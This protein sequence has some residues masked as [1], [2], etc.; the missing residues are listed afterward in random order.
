MT[1]KPNPQLSTVN[2]QLSIAPDASTHI[3]DIAPSMID[4]A[5]RTNQP[6]E[7]W[8]VPHAYHLRYAI[9]GRHH[10]LTSTAWCRQPNQ[11]ERQAMR[12]AFNIPLDAE[13]A[14]KY[15]RGW[16][17]MTITWHDRE[18]EEPKPQ[19]TQ[20]QLFDAPERTRYV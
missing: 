7:Y 11:R 15:Q 12:T 5:R 16:G 20:G 1:Q 18:A 17:L 9:A 4:Y 8:L 3:A 10:V 6:A 14:F 13:E 2:S 19:L